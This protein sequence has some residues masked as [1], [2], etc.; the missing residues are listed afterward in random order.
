[1]RLCQSSFH[2]ILWL[3]LKLCGA[4]WCCLPAVCQ[5]CTIKKIVLIIALDCITFL[6][7][8]FAICDTQT[9]S[10]G[11]LN[12]RWFIL[13]SPVGQFIKLMPQS[14]HTLG[15]TPGLIL[16][17][18]GK[19]YMY[20]LYLYV[21]GCECVS[22]FIYVCVI[23]N[24]SCSSH[25]CVC[26]CVCMLLCLYLHLCACMRFHVC[27]SLSLCVC[28]CLCAVFEMCRGGCLSL[29]IRQSSCQERQTVKQR[30]EEWERRQRK[31]WIR[32]IREREAATALLLLLVRQY[33]CLCEH[34]C[35]WF[36]LSFTPL[37]YNFWELHILIEG[38]FRYR[39]K[40]VQTK[41]KS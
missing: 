4:A 32:T 36:K 1:M 10:K 28:A 27:V 41:I 33:M 31:G 18:S 38:N 20:I 3:F 26:V 2:S 8:L 25:M 9:R 16:R 39:A 40:K 14:A 29:C 12:Y 19:T 7:V 6:C 22:V 37:R 21:G 5:N 13:A 24:C 35:V 34:M 17:Q 15:S 30:K 11:F 23:S